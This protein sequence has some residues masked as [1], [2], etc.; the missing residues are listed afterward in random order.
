MS[1]KGNDPNRMVAFIKIICYFPIG[2]L[3][4]DKVEEVAGVFLPAKDDKTNRKKTPRKREEGGGDQTPHEVKQYY[5][6][7]SHFF[8][9]KLK[10]LKTGLIKSPIF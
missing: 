8:L 7:V 10:I 4:M 9:H 2:G 5:S 3:K 1:T 6:W